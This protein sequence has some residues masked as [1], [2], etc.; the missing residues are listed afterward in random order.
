MGHDRRNSKV[1]GNHKSIVKDL[2]KLN[3]VSVKSVAQIKKF[4]DIVVGYNGKNYLFEIKNPNYPPSARK[5]T[6]DEKIFHDS[7]KG[8]ADVILNTQDIL[9]IIDYK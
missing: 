7:W 4:L 9:K 8:Q 5:L 2:E 1:D 6:Q 3:G